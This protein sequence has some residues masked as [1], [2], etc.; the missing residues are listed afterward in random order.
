MDTR[1]LRSDLFPEIEPYETGMLSVDRRHT[2]YWEQSGN[3]AGEP[4][5][6]LHGGPGAGAA[7]AHRRF[8]DPRHYRIVVLDQRGCGRSRPYADITDNTTSHLV[9]DLE[10]L[11]RKLDIER[12]MVFGGSWGATLALAYGARWPDRCSGFVLRGVFLGTRREVDWFLT[13]MRIVFPEAWRAFTGFVPEGARAD[14]LGAYYRWLIDPDPSVHRP[15]A[16]AWSR[17]EAACSNLIPKTGE[18][19]TLPR[20]DDAA[21]LALARIEAHY[22]VND[23]F[24]A[25]GTL[26]TEIEKLRDKP[27]VIIQGRYDMVCPIVT[28]DAISRA[29]P[30][31]EYVIVADASHSAMEAGIRA[32]LVRA[33]ES[34]KTRIR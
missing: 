19:G 32:A 25:D 29:W 3:P 1:Y 34:M 4:V 2:L 22:F 11:R 31:A 10:T 8:F 24:L 6:F 27:T 12:W 20:A 9:A 16:A 14:L 13:G 30:E 17:Y 33:T 15:A 28:A 5:V 23:A 7:A 18:P 21:S 26:M